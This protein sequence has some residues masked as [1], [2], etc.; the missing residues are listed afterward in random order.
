MVAEKHCQYKREWMGPNDS[1]TATPPY[2]ERSCY[3]GA[4][5]LSGDEWARRPWACGRPA[6]RDNPRAAGTPGGTWAIGPHGCSKRSSGKAAP[7]ILRDGHPPHVGWRRTDCVR[8]STV[9]IVPLGSRRGNAVDG[10]YSAAR[11]PEEARVR[12]PGDRTELNAKDLN[13]LSDRAFRCNISFIY[14]QPS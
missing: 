4:R 11:R 9:R 7:P 12:Q 13:R 8:R 3:C 14:V 1:A 6:C 2:L 5:T 10:A